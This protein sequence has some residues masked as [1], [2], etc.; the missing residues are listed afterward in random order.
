MPT[1]PTTRDWLVTGLAQVIVD[2][3]AAAAPTLRLAFDVVPDATITGEDIHWLGYQAGAALLLWDIDNAD[4]FARLHVERTR[5]LGALTML[6]VALNTLA[7]VFLLE[8]DLGAAQVSLA[9][10]QPIV[11]AT[12]SSLLSHGGALLAG[13]RGDGDG[14]GELSDLVAKSRTEDNAFARMSAQCASVIWCNGM[15]QY[16]Q[17]FAFATQADGEQWGWSAHALLPELIEAAV[18]TGQPTVASRTVER[19]SETTKGSGTDWAIGVLRRSEAL[20]NEGTAAE[21][22]YREAI[23]RLS[24]TKVRPQLAR[25]HLLYGEWLRRERRRADARKQLRAANEMFTA[26]GLSAFAERTR[27]ELLATG[28]ALRTRSADG[29]D[30]LTPQEANITRLAASGLTNPEIGAQLFISRRTVEFHLRKVF[31][32]L[33][34]TSRRQLREALPQQDS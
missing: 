5:L 19:L 25:A 27:S 6:P 18:R 21:D 11:Q 31:T 26:M 29:F 3:S 24:E 28:E 8:G 12:G 14:L 23:E 32:K 2:G 22:G 10:A 4:K 9:E 33:D 16:E 30:G 7:H 15:R 17:A 1:V 20:L 13:W 34:V